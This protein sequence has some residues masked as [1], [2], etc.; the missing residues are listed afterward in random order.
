MTMRTIMI[1]KTKLLVVT[2]AILF[3]SSCSVLMSNN[4]GKNTISSSLMDFLYPNKENSIEFKEEIP[5]LKLPI[6]V[7]IAFVPS[8]NGFYN[9]IN[10]INQQELLDRV[11]KSFVK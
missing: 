10:S 5:L 9:G 6:T 8:K 4:T 2:L 3:L 1:K 7:G 11:K